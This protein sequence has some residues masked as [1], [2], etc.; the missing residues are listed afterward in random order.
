MGYKQLP[1]LESKLAE[2]ADG[3]ARDGEHQHE[4]GCAKRANVVARCGF[5]TMRLLEAER[6]MRFQATE[7]SKTRN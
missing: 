2:S 4:S 5:Y 6:R 7:N 3:D 1:R